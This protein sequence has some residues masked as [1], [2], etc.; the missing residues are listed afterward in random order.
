M[1]AGA[2]PGEVQHR[3]HLQRQLHFTVALILQ[4]LPSPSPIGCALLSQ[5]QAPPFLFQPI[6]HKELS[7]LAW[8]VLSATAAATYF[9]SLATRANNGDLR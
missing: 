2:V 1:F 4:G 6:D 3:L 5:G 7:Q 8:D 9:G